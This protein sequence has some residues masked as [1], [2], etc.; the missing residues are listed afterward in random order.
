MHGA[1]TQWRWDGLCVVLATA[2]RD[3]AHIYHQCPLQ[4]AAMLAWT[5]LSAR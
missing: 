3:C 2:G 1:Y 4:A 5:S